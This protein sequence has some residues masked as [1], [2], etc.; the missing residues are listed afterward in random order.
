MP[1]WILSL[2]LGCVLAAALPSAS[3][4][5]TSPG[6]TFREI[7]RSVADDSRR[8]YGASRD[9]ALEAGET[10]SEDARE[11]Y[12]AAKHVG[13][14]MADDVKKGFQKGGGRAPDPTK[15]TAPPVEKP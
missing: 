12:E 3:A 4:E 10:I 5:N 1:A 8:A 9:F 15:E 7:G 14:Q 6:Q 2:V 11:A 13:P